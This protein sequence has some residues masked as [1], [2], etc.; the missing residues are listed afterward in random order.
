MSVIW[1]PSPH[2]AG[3][4]GLGESR[5]LI[6]ISS[7]PLVDFGDDGGIPGINT[8]DSPLT[9]DFPDIFMTTSYSPINMIIAPQD[10]L[11]A[12]TSS[13]PS[14]FCYADIDGSPIN[15]YIIFKNIDD[16]YEL[17]RTIR[18]STNAIG[19]CQRVE[20]LN[21]FSPWT[22][23]KDIANEWFKAQSSA[24]RTILTQ[25]VVNKLNTSFEG[26]LML[27]TTSFNDLQISLPY[28]KSN[29]S[30]MKYIIEAT[31]NKVVESALSAN[32][33]NSNSN[34]SPQAHPSSSSNEFPHSPGILPSPMDLMIKSSTRHNIVNGHPSPPLEIPECT[35]SNFL[36]SPCCPPSPRQSDVDSKQHPD[37]ESS[38]FQDPPAI[39]LKCVP[40]LEALLKGD[41][42]TG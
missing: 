9:S 16:A 19:D 21:N 7:S 41:S 37:S 14:I 5:I 30:M 31:H 23:S 11:S 36:Q 6:T 17:I 3:N 35:K 33:N 26:Q 20:Q 27:R 40:I 15:K 39:E 29:T 32:T 34:R 12:H 28:N 18:E 25:R 8:P 22:L 1:K 38:E 13:L 42:Y 4:Y 24:A 10:I 2:I